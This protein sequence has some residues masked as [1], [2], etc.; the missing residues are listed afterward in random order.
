LNTKLSE[1]KTSVKLTDGKAYLM[2]REAK[3]IILSEV[4]KVAKCK[5]CA[6]PMAKCMCKKM[7]EATSNDEIKTAGCNCPPTCSCGGKGSCDG[8]CECKTAN[9]NTEIKKE[10]QTVSPKSVDKLEDDPDINQSSGPGQGK[11]HADEAHSLGI[12][13]KKPSEGMEEPSVP[14]APEGGQLK[15]EHT[16]DN[17]LE[18]PTIPAGGGM[19]PDY[20]QN[21]KNTPEKLDQTLGKEN[22]IAAMAEIRDRA[23]KIAGQLLKAQQITIDELP[24]K[25]TEL[26][27]AGSRVLDDY[28]NMMKAAST[29]KGLQK[30]ANVGSPETS[31]QINTPATDDEQVTLKDNIQGLFKLDKRNRDYESHS[32]SNPRLWR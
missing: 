6:K 10:S 4:I 21:E 16:Y 17:A 12:D 18:G 24:D 32:G 27:K 3:S 5:K 31:F 1:G 30:A 22:D 19:N 8:S 23:T 20:D 9:K 26:A 13:E 7:E 25:I 11:T 2:D 15:R 28:E 29:K 14:E